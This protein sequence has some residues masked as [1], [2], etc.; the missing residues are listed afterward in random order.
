[1]RALFHVVVQFEEG[2]PLM[3]NGDAYE[4]GLARDVVRWPSRQMA[5]GPRWLSSRPG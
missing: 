3:F 1:V 4:H 2:G 5:A